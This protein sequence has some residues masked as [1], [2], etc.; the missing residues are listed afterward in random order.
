MLSFWGEGSNMIQEYISKQDMIIL[1]A[2]DV[3]NDSGLAGITFKNLAYKANMT[4]DQLYKYYGDTNDVLVDVVKYYF[5]FDK[6]LRNTVDGK[7]ITYL[8]KIRFY[9]D[10]YAK[11]YD[12]YPAIAAIMLHY[13]EFLH[14]IDT[15]EIVTE[16]TVKRREFV[17]KLFRCAI[18]NGETKTELTANDLTEVLTGHIMLLTLNR[19]FMP[20]T[21]PFSIC[22]EEFIDKLY[23]IISA[24]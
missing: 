20:Y 21:E 4:E 18:D 1:T 3:I 23:A 14:N 6:S 11:Y 5:E 10:Q 24:K 15:R 19:R 2:I 12:T 8:E 16:G 13:E 17:E 7:D 22:L 9:T